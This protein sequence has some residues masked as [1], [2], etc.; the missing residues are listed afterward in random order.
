VEWG[1]E[2]AS[3]VGKLGLQHVAATVILPRHEVILRQIALPGVT[4]K[5]LDAAISFQLDTLHPYNEGD[6]VASWARLEGSDA[7]AV[8]IAR[9]DHVDAYVTLFAE[10]GIKLAGFTCSGIAVHSALRVFGA[11]PAQPLLA[12]EYSESGVEIY[13]ESAAKPL[14]SVA[15]DLAPEESPD[16]VIALAA[17]ELRIEEAPAPTP[18]GDLVGS[19]ARPL[20]AALS[21]AYPRGTS[22]LNLLPVE[23]R[24]IR[25]PWE[26]VPT[27]ALG[28]AVVLGLIAMV[29]LPRIRDRQYQET[30]N[31]EIA[32]VEPQALQAAAMDKQIQDTRARAALL[33]KVRTQSKIDMDVLSELTTLLAPPAWVRSLELNETQVRVTGEAPQASPLVKRFDESRFFEGSEFVAPPARSNRGETF[34]I[35]SKRT[36]AK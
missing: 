23:A 27:A 29:A 15:F 7:V 16:R 9:R 19:P 35:R 33:D 1:A 26:W 32:K 2:Y 22:A 14:L 5:D 3:F 10:A 8:A 18:L 4:D 20:A 30:L 17:A 21:S 6:V 24:E 12:V 34:S 31:V 36:E 28:T 13:G 11:K 25:S